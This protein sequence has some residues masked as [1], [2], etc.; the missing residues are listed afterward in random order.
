[1]SSM[2]ARHERPQYPDSDI[3]DVNVALLDFDTVPGSFSITCLLS[4]SS[5]VR[6]QLFCEGLTITITQAQV[7]Y[8]YGHERHEFK[9]R[10]NAY[11]SQNRA[12]IK[13]VRQRDPSLVYC[14]Y[15]DALKTHHLCQDIVEFSSRA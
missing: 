14:T 1:M 15:A 2:A 11:L 9:T 6:L 4:E 3:A 8:D 10:A 13:A 7:I 5:D 12:F